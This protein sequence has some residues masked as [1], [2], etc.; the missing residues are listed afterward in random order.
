MLSS[1]ISLLQPE[2]VSRTAQAAAEIAGE[3]PSNFL[4][5]II[6]TFI[7]IIIYTL[8]LLSYFLGLS[9]NV[10]HTLRGV[11]HCTG[12]SRDCR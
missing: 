1:T 5:R 10:W 6:N 2:G 4:S 12:G 9:P 3:G 8:Y 7:M 11:T